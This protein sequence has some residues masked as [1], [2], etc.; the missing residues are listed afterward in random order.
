MSG[1]CRYCQRKKLH[2]DI[3]LCLFVNQKNGNG[4]DLLCIYRIVDNKIVFLTFGELT[5]QLESCRGFDWY[6]VC[7]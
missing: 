6:L 1:A 3:N 5:L 7:D 4:L 2:K